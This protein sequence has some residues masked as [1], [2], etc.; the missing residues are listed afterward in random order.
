MF[1]CTECGQEFDIKP[2]YCDCGNDIFEEIVK[3]KTLQATKPEKTVFSSQSSQNISV[4]FQPINSTEN[5][6]EKTKTETKKLSDNIVDMPSLIIFLA[7]IVLSILSIIFIGKD[8][9]DKMAQEEQ[10]PEKVKNEIVK[11]NN[12]PTIGNIWKESKKTIDNPALKV[13]P[14]IVKQNNIQTTKKISQQQ[15]NINNTAKS[16]ITSNKTPAPVQTSKTQTTNV[17]TKVQ[18][19][20]TKPVQTTVNPEVA[21]KELANYKIALRNKLAGKINFT[22]IIGDGNCVI[23]FKLDTAG[24][25]IDRK[26]SVQSDN[27]SLNNAVFNAVKNT[28]TYQSPPTAYKNETLTFSVKMYGGRFDVTLN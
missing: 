3:E 28:P 24:N 17:Q 12:I 10:T 4:K 18:A 8:S 22:Q 19:T 1:K 27:D 20:Q 13:Q 9:L 15:T 2:D 16:K 7:C 21:K 6:Q 26:F 14:T 11:T 23:T 25:L 5:T